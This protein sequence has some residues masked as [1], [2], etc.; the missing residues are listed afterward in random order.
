MAFDKGL[1]CTVHAGMHLVHP[2]LQRQTAAEEKCRR[3]A[4]PT[5]SYYRVP[6]PEV[7]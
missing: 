4:K 2:R 7:A 5:C 6:S 3:L 1:E